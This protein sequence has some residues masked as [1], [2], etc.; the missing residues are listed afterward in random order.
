M[1]F[2]PIIRRVRGSGI[3]YVNTHYA[4]DALEE[5]EGQEILLDMEVDVST[6][7][8]SFRAYDMDE[9]EICVIELEDVENMEE[10]VFG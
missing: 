3:V 9:N 10:A 2:T 7:R 5:Y 8:R 1:S 4:N 6:E